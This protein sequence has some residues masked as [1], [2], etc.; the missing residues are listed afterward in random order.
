L[1]EI[2]W[3]PEGDR[4]L[5]A[6]RDGSASVWDATSGEELFTL[7]GHTAEIW[8]WLAGE[9]AAWSPDGTRAATCSMD[10]T[11][12]VWDLSPVPTLVGHPFRALASWSP[13]GDRVLSVGGTGDGTARIW[14]SS[15][16]AELL[17]IEHGTTEVGMPSSWSPS[18]DR[19]AIGSLTGKTTIWDATTGA[20]LLT[21]AVPEHDG[22]TIPAWSPDG[23]LI[24]IGHTYDGS[25]RFWDAD[26]GEE[27]EFLYTYTSDGEWDWEYGN[28]IHLLEWS[29]TGDKILSSAF[30]TYEP[31]RIWGTITGEGLLTTIEANAPSVASWSPDGRRIATYGYDGGNTLDAE[32][33]KKLLEFSGH[34]GEVRGATWSPSGERIATSGLDGTVIVRDAQDGLEV[35]R[36]PIGVAVNSIDWS[37]DGREILV[38]YAGKIV[39]LPIWNSAQELI[40]YTYDCCVVRE[41]SPEDRELYGLPPAE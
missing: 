31:L 2:V 22:D 9:C 30:R 5:T 24:A 14:D 20:E 8:G 16:G 19:F 18:G 26:N 11:A 39:I 1:N 32:S 23:S 10:G 3:S 38:S 34:T 15:T 37:P 13:A 33:G 17:V 36:Y 40:D 21:I 6:L 12:M 7:R 27:K 29:P 25:I 35:L 41:L 28:Y 4:I